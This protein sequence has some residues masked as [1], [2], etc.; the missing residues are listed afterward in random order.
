MEIVH[1]FFKLV[2]ER[3]SPP[4]ALVSDM[5]ETDE[6]K[7]KKKL[8]SVGGSGGCTETPWRKVLSSSFFN[9][10]SKSRGGGHSPFQPL[11]FSCRRLWLYLAL[12][13]IS[14]ICHSFHKG[15]I[16][17]NAFSPFLH[18]E[19][20]WRLP[21]LLN[22]FV[23][24]LLVIVSCVANNSKKSAILLIGVTCLYE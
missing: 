10:I 17:Y 6:H 24:A 2:G 3:L 19:E 12:L 16:H 14:Y 1:L 11:P 8:S 13:L 21:Q 23:I 20:R 18:L 9:S 15:K 4:K 7:T 5:F 22:F